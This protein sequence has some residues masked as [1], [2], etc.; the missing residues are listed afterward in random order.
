MWRW[1]YNVAYINYQWCNTCNA[2]TCHNHST[3][4]DCATKKNEERIRIWN[5]QD[6]DTKLNDL[7]VRLEKL[8]RG[9]IMLA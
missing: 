3:C 6:V 5:A 9:P 4:M 8:E 2:E 7:R 1:K